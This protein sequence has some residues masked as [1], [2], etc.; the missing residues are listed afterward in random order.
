MRCPTRSNPRKRVV[1]P[2]KSGPVTT[3]RHPHYPSIRLRNGALGNGLPFLGRGVYP[4]LSGVPS[5]TQMW[6]VA[7]FMSVTARVASRCRCAAGSCRW[8]WGED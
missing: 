5:S 1:H 4:L 7:S 6:H 2:T 8:V 3:M